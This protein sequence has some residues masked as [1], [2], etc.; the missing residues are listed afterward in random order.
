MGNFIK[1]KGA[2]ITFYAFLIIVALCLIFITY[3]VFAADTSVTPSSFDASKNVSQLYNFTITNQNITANITR[4]SIGT[5]DFIIA[6]E[7]NGTSASF[8]TLTTAPVSAIWEGSQLIANGTTQNFWFNATFSQSGNYNITITTRDEAYGGSVENITLIPV[9]VTEVY[10]QNNLTGYVTYTDGSGV[11]SYNLT[12]QQGWTPG[13]DTTTDSNGYYEFNSVTQGLYS[14]EQDVGPS[15]RYD[16]TSLM[17]LVIDDLED[18]NN[19][20]NVSGETKLNLTIYNV[21]V[22]TNISNLNQTNYDNGDVLAVKINATNNEDSAINFEFFFEFGDE[23][24]PSSYN[25]TEEVVEIAAGAT[26]IRTL[27]ITIPQSNTQS[28]VETRAGVD[29]QYNRSYTNGNLTVEL[30][31]RER[32]YVDVNLPAVAI[33]LVSPSNAYS[34]S[35]NNISFQYNITKVGFLE[36]S[37]NCNLVLNGIDNVSDTNNPISIISASPNYNGTINVTLPEGNYNWTIKCN[38]TMQSSGIVWANENWSLNIIA[39]DT[40]SP[41]IHIVWPGDNYNLSTAHMSSD[42]NISDN[43]QI[44]NLTRYI[45]NSSN[46]LVNVNSTELSG[47]FNQSTNAD[48]YFEYGLPSYDAYKWN[49]Y[50]CDNSS[51]CAWSAEGNYTVNYSEQ[52]E[53]LNITVVKYLENS[54]VN[55]SLFAQFIINVTNNNDYN[56]TD[57]L[58]NDTG[59]GMESGISF[60]DRPGDSIPPYTS[61]VPSAS[62]AWRINVSANSTSQILVIFKTGMMNDTYTNP[63][64]VTN[65][66]G[67]EIA[68][69]EM[70]YILAGENCSSGEMGD[71][72]LT[73]TSPSDGGALTSAPFIFNYS[74]VGSGTISNCSL[75]GNFT[76]TWLENQTNTSVTMGGQNNSFTIENLSDGTYLWNIKCMNGESVIFWADSNRT[77]SVSTSGGNNAPSVVLDSF[78][79]QG[80]PISVYNNISGDMMLFV[81]EE[82]IIKG[83]VND[84]DLVNWTISLKNSSGIINASLCFNT[85][86]VEGDFCSWNTSLYCS[87]ECEDYTIVLNASDSSGNT[88]S[89]FFENITIDNSAPSISDIITNEIFGEPSTWIGDVNISDNYLWRVDGMIFDEN[90][91]LVLETNYLCNESESECDY[92]GSGAFNFSWNWDNYFLNSIRVPII[93]GGLFVDYPDDYIATVPGCLAQNGVDYDCGG[94]CVDQEVC[95]SYQWYLAYNMSILTENRTFLGLTN[96]QLCSREGCLVNA[97]AIQNGTSKFKVQSQ[98]LNFSDGQWSNENLTE[99]TIYNVEE[100]KTL[101]LSFA[102]P[103]AG[104]YSLAFR[105]QDYW[106]ASISSVRDALNLNE[107][108]SGLNATL[109]EF[110]DQGFVTGTVNIEGYANGTEFANWTISIRNLTTMINSSLCFG[111][112]SVD[113]TFCSWNTSLYCSGECKNYTV[114]LTLLAPSDGDNSVWQSNIIIDNHAPDIDFLLVN[115]SDSSEVFAR[116]N[117]SDDYLYEV[118]AD[119][120]NDSN[121]TLFEWGRFCGEGQEDNCPDVFEGTFNKSWGKRIFQLNSS[122]LSVSNKLGFSDMPGV[123]TLLIPGCLDAAGDGNYDCGGAC[124]N[125]TVCDTYRWWLVYND[126]QN[127]N[128]TILGL[129]NDQQCI[130]GCHVNTSVIVSGDSKFKIQLDKYDFSNGQWIYENLTEITLYSIGNPNN[131]NITSSTIDEG[132]FSFAFEAEDEVGW[133]RISSMD[134]SIEAEEEENVNYTLNVNLLNPGRPNIGETLMFLINFTNTGSTVIS[135]L[136]LSDEFDLNYNYTSASLT[137]DV[138]NLETYTLSWNNISVN[139]AQN[140]SYLLYV[141]FTAFLTTNSSINDVDYTAYSSSGSSSI[142]S[143]SLNFEIGENIA[144]TVSFI[145]ATSTEAGNYSGNSIWANVSAGDSSV[146]DTITIFLFN[147]TGLYDSSAI[148]PSN[149]SN[150]YAFFNFTNLPEGTYF[151][152]ATANDTWGNSNLTE[153]RVIILNSSEENITAPQLISAIITDADNFYSVY[154]KYVNISVNA[155]GSTPLI[156]TANFSALSG[157]TCVNGDGTVNLTL[158][159]GLYKG[160]CDISAGV[161]T[162]QPSPRQIYILVLDSNHNINYTNVEILVHNMG[163]PVMNESCM[164]FGSDT[165][166]FTEVIDFGDIDFVMDVEMNISCKSEG[167]VNLPNYRDANLINISGINMSSRE[168]ADKL[169]DLPRA[170]QPRITPPHQFGDSRIYINSTYFTEFANSIATIKFFNLPFVSTPN[171]AEDEGAAGV[172]TSTVIWASNGFDSAMGVITGNITFTVLG[173]SGYNVTDNTKPFLTINYPLASSE[174]TDTTPTINATLNGTGTEISSAYFF[175]NNA[176]IGYFN[177]SGNTSNCANTAGSEIYNCVFTSSELSDGDKNLTVYAYDTGGSAGNMNSSQVL[178]TLS[179]C[180]S[181]ITNTTWSGWTNESCFETQM[182]QSRFL[183]Q[184]D[185]NSCGEIEN[186]TIYDYQFVGPTLQNTTFGAWYNASSCYANNTQDQQQNATQY[187]IFGCAS[188]TTVYNYQ[189]DSCDFCSYNITNSTGE[190]TNESCLS[191]NLMNQTRTIIQYDSNYSTCYAVTGLAEDNYTN[192]TI[193]EYRTTEFCDYDSAYPQF[194]NPTT[195]PLSSERYNSSL[196]YWFNITLANTNATAGIEFDGVN[197][198]LSNLS[199]NFYKTFATLGAGTYSYYYWTYGNGLSH[200]YGVSQTYSYIVNRTTSS[201]TSS[202]TSSIPY[203]TPSDYSAS[204]SNDGDEDCV[205]VLTRDGITI[206]SGSSVSDNS[207]L[208]GGNHT[209]NY[210]TAGCVNYSA[211]SDVKIL[212]ITLAPRVCTIETNNEWARPYN[213]AIISS[214]NCS[215][216]A[217][218]DDGA[219]NFTKNLVSITSPDSQTDAGTFDYSCGWLAGENYSACTPNTD[220]LIISKLSSTNILLIDPV[221]PIQYP[222]PSNFSCYN[223]N[224]ISVTLMV[225]GVDKTSENGLLVVRAANDSYAVNCSS[226]GNQNYN[227]SSDSG[228][229]T[230][231]KGT[232]S[233]TLTSSAGWDPLTYP[234]STTINYSESNG[235]DADVIYKIYRDNVDKGSGEIITLGFGSYVYKLNSTG[236]QNY[237]SI[238]S[239]DTNTLAITQGS[240]TTNV[241]VSPSSPITYGLASNFSCINS[242]GIITNMT[243]NGIDKISEMGLNVTRARGSYSINCSFEGN[244]NYTGSSDVA[245]YTINP[246]EPTLIKYLNGEDASLDVTYPQQVNASG[247]TIGGTLAIYQDGVEIVNGD[248]STLGVAYYRFDFNVTGNENYTDL[249]ESLWANVTQ[250][251]SPLTLLINGTE[252]NQTGVYGVQTNVSVTLENNEQS[253]IL[254]Q[255]GLNITDQNNLLRTLSAGSYNFT[256]I[257]PAT[258]NYTALTVTRWGDI[259]QAT[260][261]ITEA[262]NGVDNNLTVTYP[263]QVNASGSTT[264]GTLAIYRDGVSITNGQN[265]SLA[266]VNYRFDFNVTGNENYTTI[267]RTLYATINKATGSVFVYANNSHSGLAVAANTSVWLNATLENGVGIISLHNDGSLINSGTS[268]IG[269]LT[270]WTDVDLYNITAIYSGN[271]NYTSSSDTI[272]VSVYGSET[273]TIDNETIS[274]DENTTNA[275]LPANSSLPIITIGVNSA[276]ASVSI[277]L[278]NL[279]NSTG[280]VTLGNNT[281]ILERTGDENYSLEIPGNTTINGCPGWDGKIYLPLVNTS[282]ALFSSPSGTLNIVIGVGSNTCSLNFSGPVKIIIGGMTGKKAAWSNSTS[283]VEIS[284]ECNNLTSP[285]TNIYSNSTPKECYKN[286]G[287]DLAVW[288]YHLTNFAAYT[289]ATTSPGGGGGGGASC[290]T[291][292]NCTQWSL[293]ING[294]Q[295]RNCAKIKPACSVNTTEPSEVQSC[296]AINQTITIPS[297]GEKNQTETIP[298]EGEPTPTE[299]TKPISEITWIIIVVALIIIAGLIYWFVKK[300]NK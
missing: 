290:A 280:S 146:I 158:S 289:P 166:N 296:G 228:V 291:T 65:S 136:T 111:N 44:K 87:G 5:S 50:G 55:C 121:Y 129:V 41:V 128:K 198:S 254:Y 204:E 108:G 221:S 127:D 201:L 56:V 7:T 299:T 98:I 247:S 141:N 80:T 83:E 188:N 47:I 183:T 59:L 30:E 18:L 170:I 85:S 15:Q 252:G 119:I 54:T 171:L 89:T 208:A 199:N 143:S 243:I 217:G 216:S 154:D 25:Y 133:T 125:L 192:Q 152:N 32:Q 6:A 272:W 9:S 275:V 286:S 187:D 300:K 159:D 285:P 104:N 132:N 211:S 157:V 173:F 279:L 45:W 229:Y 63:I 148:T 191:S 196:S 249:S 277:D 120:L 124:I 179:S 167:R 175:I 113:G 81:G 135:N 70:N 90:D 189:A 257:A 58:V 267:S 31:K 46:D 263:Q 262:L 14:L 293:C 273:Q 207:I 96:E 71:I 165:I 177:S 245:S 203:G 134:F 22:Y 225:N 265:Y 260:P 48:Y 276:N 147:T 193:I 93:Y 52:V 94:A 180:V 298:E 206:D 261:T 212:E 73:L 19:S 4:V 17:E 97:S 248:N 142:G 117:I 236:G 126:S 51:N 149:P 178:F 268:P 281:L 186:Q 160:S 153:T 114:N 131:Q 86:V 123:S 182:N 106:W 156:V 60:W 122:Q 227:S 161:N 297:E 21:T 271:E 75:W 79:Y 27:S 138:I 3:F 105:A 287:N 78:S 137:P 164:R 255:D 37:E 259:S 39:G 246:A 209:Y 238:D 185:S 219:M 294:S 64:N 101:N 95:S 38:E 13:N 231:N 215:V 235:G 112:Y 202:V 33:H 2:R 150:A 49:L 61:Y 269:N 242:G 88:N 84:T 253:F 66:S 155:S 190:W 239:I 230:V 82:V 116:V 62:I 162:T 11:E 288:T 57:I 283:L 274:L 223:L 77:F 144:P 292:W 35:N 256:A 169:R 258:Q 12:L 140:Q 1:S 241:S 26:E 181:N 234:T 237:S 74:V 24:T 226:A 115:T 40:T 240:T 43:I 139:L 244:E 184:Y 214:T 20:V 53:A 10:S 67:S 200:R 172:N 278:I 118:R 102:T 264:G 295:T 176:L 28:N 151:L 42:W 210:S 8:D 76:G 174:I 103:E 107:D 16:P 72:T 251:T 29:T 218:T 197:Y 213:A 100:W 69:T 224:G 168:Q 92:P 23:N 194:S 109:D 36:Y 232:L 195:A 99:I 110:T 250:A 222:T 68:S 270:N 233:G 284:T 205:Y 163:V 266:A 220:T 91:S 145:E 34:T 282:S 130:G